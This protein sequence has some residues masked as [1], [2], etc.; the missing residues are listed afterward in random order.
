LKGNGIDCRNDAIATT[1]V[2]ITAL[3]TRLMGINLDGWAGL[4]VSIFII[5]NGILLIREAI[6]PIIGE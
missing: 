5:Y 2:L 4:G 3:I 6:N 1:V